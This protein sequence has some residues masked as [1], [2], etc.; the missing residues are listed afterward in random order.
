MKRGRSSRRESNI[1]ASKPKNQISM[2]GSK[3]A[4]TGGSLA[5]TTKEFAR[6]FGTMRWQLDRA[7]SGTGI[8]D[9][10]THEL[11]QRKKYVHVN[12]IACVR[13]LFLRTAGMWVCREVGG[14][15]RVLLLS[16]GMAWN[17]VTFQGAN[18]HPR[19]PYLHLAQKEGLRHRGPWN[20]GMWQEW[21]LDM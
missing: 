20:G 21:G 4:Q 17:L 11:L 1:A 18:C 2:Y 19:P 12:C 13:M 8:H 5:V 9:S 7:G 6:P 15:S 3:S 14:D 10:D 16:W